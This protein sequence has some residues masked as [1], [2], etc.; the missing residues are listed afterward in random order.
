VFLIK[1]WR[2]KAQGVQHRV[3]ATAPPRLVCKGLHQ[4]ASQAP[5]AQGVGPAVQA[6]EVEIGRG[7]V[8]RTFV[9]RLGRL[10]LERSLAAHDVRRGGDE[11][12]GVRVELR[13]RHDVRERR[14]RLV[15]QPA[16]LG[17]GGI[18]GGV[19]WGMAANETLGLVYVPISDKKIFGFPSPG[20][21]NPGLY[22]L[23][24][25]TGEQR[26]QY[27]R[28]SRC[29][30]QECVYGL[31]AAAIAANDIVVTGSMDGYLE[32]LHAQ[33]GERLWSYD[34]WRSFDTVNGVSAVGGGFDA[35]G[36][37]LADD[38]LVVSAGYAYVGQ[39]RGGNAFLVFEVDDES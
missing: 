13:A 33:S 6:I 15:G 23:D 12:G 39:P 11:T 29:D 35:H 9:G 21:P 2:L 8:R 20:E 24:I 34:A 25:A 5:T 22:A 38:L 10:F 36:A 1:A 3:A 31:S 28:D 16:Q 7:G 19:H 18:I 17:R 37:L 14:L 26:W 4:L 27:T 32:V 30:T